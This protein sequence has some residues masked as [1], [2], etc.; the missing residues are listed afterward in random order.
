M[1]DKQKHLEF[2]QSIISRMAG[3]LFFLKG[4][5][6]TLMAGLFALATKDSDSRFVFIA[7]LPVFV[8][9][10]LDGFF[11]SQER[12]FRNLYKDV[13]KLKDKDIDFS[14]DTSKYKV[15][16][17]NTWIA[18]TFS[19]TLILFYLSLLLAMTVII[20][21]INGNQ[22]NSYHRDC[23]HG[24]RVEKNH[25]L[26]HDRVEQK[27]KEDDEKGTIKLPNNWR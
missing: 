24:R 7:Y 23:Y 18:S 25:N 2:V 13:T 15:Y 26:L 12:L 21:L 14:M 19:R 4:W 27:L 22:V 17:K 9:W 3:N 6:V 16:F 10:F 8:F 1:T 11:L 5:T 20:F